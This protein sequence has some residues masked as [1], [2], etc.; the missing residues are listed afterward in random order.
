MKLH[1]SF[2][3][4]PFKFCAYMEL[5]SD[6]FDWHCCVLK[7]ERNSCALTPDAAWSHQCKGC[8]LQSRRLLRIGLLLSDN[9][10]AP[11]IWRPC[12]KLHPLARAMPKTGAACTAHRRKA[13][14]P[15][16]LALSSNLL[17]LLPRYLNSVYAC[18][19]D[20]ARPLYIC[21]QRAQSAPRVLQ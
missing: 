21:K 15:P 12:N 14:V 10:C 9:L 5:W 1:T 8:P 6:I 17:P 2:V 16:W 18:T 13:I 19:Y 7:S 4:F 11:S 3:C 20:T